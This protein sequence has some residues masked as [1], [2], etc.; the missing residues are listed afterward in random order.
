MITDL[1]E[2]ECANILIIDDET[3]NLEI[4]NELLQ[5]KGFSNINLFSNPEKALEYYQHTPPD[6][7][8]LDLNMPVLTGFEVMQ[9]FNEINHIPKPPVIVITAQNNRKTRVQ[10]LDKEAR[11]FLSKPFDNEEVICRICNL[12]EM[13]LAH[14]ENL[15][16]TNNLEVII[17]KRTQELKNTQKEMIER[18]G[19]AAEYKDNE[20]AHHTIRV[21]H[22]TEILAL[23]LGL[24]TQRCGNGRHSAGDF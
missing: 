11:D 13:H 17:G 7:V 15:E 5:A 16:Y 20:T 24:S 1:Q 12:L 19:L 6:I 18:L 2:L 14:K 10:A 21:G 22:Y 8:L 4:L 9:R 3:I 23:A